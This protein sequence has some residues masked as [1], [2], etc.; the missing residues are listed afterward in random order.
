MFEQLEARGTTGAGAKRLRRLRRSAALR[1][2]TAET[3]LRA[4]QFI[5]PLFVHG[6]R[7]IDNPIPSMPGHAQRS[8]EL[9]ASEVDAVSELGIP[10]VLLFGIPIEKDAIGSE[11]WSASGPVPRAIAAIKSRAPDL[12]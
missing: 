8:V 1:D 5:L 11:A 3:S 4:Q 6:E 2:L 7:G 9:L 10:G 12:V